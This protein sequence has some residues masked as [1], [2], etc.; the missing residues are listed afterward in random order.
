MIGG[1]ELG[2]L[3]SAVTRYTA[4][5]AGYVDPVPFEDVFEIVDGIPA[6]TFAPMMRVRASGLTF[7]NIIQAIVNTTRVMENAA[8]IGW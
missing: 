4:G 5:G 6:I 1:N 8:A 3:S 2:G 7:A